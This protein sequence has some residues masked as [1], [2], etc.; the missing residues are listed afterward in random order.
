MVITDLRMPDGTGLDVLETSKEL[1]PDT[2]VIVVTAFATAE[3]AIAAMKPG[4]YDYLTKPFKVD[5]I[6]L[7]VERALEKRALLRDNVVLRDEIEGRYR[8]DRMLGKSAAMQRVFELIARS[9]RR[10]P[11]C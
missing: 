7:V 1:H 3:T 6:G 11:A 8:L 5:E 2:E 9:R 4:A 10:A